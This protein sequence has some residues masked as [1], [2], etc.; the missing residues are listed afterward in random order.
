MIE[1]VKAVVLIGNNTGCN[2]IFDLVRNRSQ[3]RMVKC[4]T[5]PCHS[6]IS[7]HFLWPEALFFECVASC[8]RQLA[9][10][11]LFWRI[12]TG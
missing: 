9:F 8:L 2:V 7:L 4:E 12:S 5:R 6:P 1:Q 11:P 10:F 3:S